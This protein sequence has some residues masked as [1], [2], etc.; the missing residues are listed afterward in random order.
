MGGSNTNDSL[1][2]G[3]FNITD[4]ADYRE[5]MSSI[6]PGASADWIDYMATDLYL[7]ILN[8]SYGYTDHIS[9]T[10]LTM[11]DLLFRCN[12]LALARAL[13]GTTHQYEFGVFPA[14]HAED[15]A[16][17]FSDNGVGMSSLETAIAL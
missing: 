10:A 14:M 9:R 1:F 2:F 6:L 4:D 15:V 17:T 12:G 13:N 5:W 8:G 7:P 11:Q 16:Y 3:S